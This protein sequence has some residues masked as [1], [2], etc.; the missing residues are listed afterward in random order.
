MPSPG[1][2][3]PRPAGRI[4]TAARRV[5]ARLVRGVGVVVFGLGVVLVL[6]GVWI[7]GARRGRLAAEAQLQAAPSFDAV[8]ASGPVVAGAAGPASAAGRATA[9]PATPGHKRVAASQGPAARL[10]RVVRFGGAGDGVA[11]RRDAAAPAAEAAATQSS[12]ARPG[13]RFAVSA[14]PVARHG[15]PRETAAAPTPVPTPLP[16]P[17]R[18]VIHAI[19]VDRPVVPIG[20]TVEAVDNDLLRSVWET[21]DDA[22]GWHETSARPGQVGNTVVSG[23]NNI[24]G[25]IFRRLHELAVGDQI[26]LRSGSAEI[27]YAVQT[28]FI[29]REAGASPIERAANNRWIEPTDDER[30]TLVTCY[31]PWGNSH[32]LILIAR[33]IVV[34]AP[35]ATPGAAP[36]AVGLGR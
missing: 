7:D 27:R 22:A 16:P 8:L 4:R 25:A 20:W 28:R 30:L 31:P 15:V 21:A 19:D 35:T 6:V 32:R 12:A 1:A 29:V 14:P 9:P 3:P 34:I 5:A 26:A 11:P 23:H 10:R 17:D 24:A 33:P 18:I 2:A 36:D 13:K